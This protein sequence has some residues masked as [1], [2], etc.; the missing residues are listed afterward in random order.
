ML[1][2]TLVAVISLTCL[3]PATASLSRRVRSEAR[4]SLPRLA[5]TPIRP[6]AASNEYRLTATTEVLLN[7][8]PCR[9]EDV[10][11]GATII[12]LETVSNENREILRVHFETPSSSV[13]SARK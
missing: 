2:W 4:P 6:A 11:D 10:P 9:Y 3:A 1:R 13:H 5:L 8:R 12:L 7:G